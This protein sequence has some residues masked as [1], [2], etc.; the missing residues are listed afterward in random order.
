LDES[1]IIVYNEESNKFV[2]ELKKKVIRA[3]MPYEFDGLK[4]FS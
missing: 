2:K 3:Y 4:E 1:H